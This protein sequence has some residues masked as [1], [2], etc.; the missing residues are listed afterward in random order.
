M[1]MNS[2][3]GFWLMPSHNRPAKLKKIFFDMKATG[4]STA[5][6][7]LIN[8]TDWANNL[9]FYEM[10]RPQLPQ[11]WHYRILGK[12]ANDMGPKIREFTERVLS[13]YKDRG[14]EWVGLLCDD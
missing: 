13:P 11:H 5:G 8:E 14:V 9:K 7:V 10:I 2:A 4:V 3:N 1:E 12:K 6:Y